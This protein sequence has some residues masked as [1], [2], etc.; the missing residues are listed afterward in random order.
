MDSKRQAWYLADGTTDPTAVSPPEGM[1]ASRISTD[2][3]QAIITDKEGRVWSWQPGGTPVRADD[4]SRPYT[5][6]VLAGGRITAV[7]RQGGM[8]TWSLDGQGRPGQPGSTPPR[9]P[10]WNQPAWTASH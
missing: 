2:K 7:S 5:Q 1:K 6:A 9:H 4:G 3:N 10:P 8:F